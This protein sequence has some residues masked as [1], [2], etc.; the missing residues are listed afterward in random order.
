VEG[1][2][3]KKVYRGLALLVALGVVAQAAAIAYAWFAV[4]GDLEAGS[5][6]TDDFEG[7]A[8]HAAH[9]IVGMMVIPLAALLLLVVSPFTKVRGASKRAGLVL[10]AVVAQVVLAIVSFSAAAVG[11]LHGVNALV[12]LGAALLAARGISQ[13]AAPA[14]SVDV[15][16][17]AG[18]P[19]S[20][21]HV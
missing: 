6:L 18:A 15:P 16:R 13:S 3:V 17:Q 1:D 19:Q 5:V 20:T 12:V 9:G 7:N 2:V 14:G 4:I 21:T 8:G 11:A 10:L